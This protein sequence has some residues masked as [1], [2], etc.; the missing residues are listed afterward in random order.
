MEHPP[1][2]VIPNSWEPQIEL[3]YAMLLG[4]IDGDGSCY[5]RRT[6][7]GGSYVVIYSHTTEEVTQVEALC[8]LAGLPHKT[9]APPSLRCKD[10]S[11]VYTTRCCRTPI[12]ET[13]VVDLANFVYIR[14]A[15]QCLR[16][17][18][19]AGLF[20]ADGSVSRTAVIDSV[21]EN[22]LRMVREILFAD[23]IQST[24]IT[25]KQPV[26]AY[27]GRNMWRICIRRGRFLARFVEMYCRILTVDSVPMGILP[28]KLGR[29]S[30]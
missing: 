19:V 7:R 6:H 17:A 12:V 16:R 21:N 18:F 26:R 28:S 1:V 4:W 3:A 8:R 13:I 29:M 14:A 5:L 27:G 22:K 20:N 15:A 25:Y 23:A 30:R 24:L 9:T 11:P 10:G 2:I